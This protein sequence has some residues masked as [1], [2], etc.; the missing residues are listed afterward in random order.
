MISLLFEDHLKFSFFA[1]HIQNAEPAAVT[2]WNIGFTP[3]FDKKAATAA[4]MPHGMSV[5]SQTRLMKQIQ[6]KFLETYGGQDSDITRGFAFGNGPLDSG[7]KV[8]Q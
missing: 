5:I 3:M 4:M 8:T 2:P 6:L 7:W 1:Y